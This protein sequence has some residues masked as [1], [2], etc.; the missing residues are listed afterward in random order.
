MYDTLIS[1]V[2][3]YCACWRWAPKCSSLDKIAPLSEG[4][5]SHRYLRHSKDS[6]PWLQPHKRNA[7]LSLKEQRPI[8]PSLYLAFPH[9]TDNCLSQNHPMHKYNCLARQFYNIS[10]GYSLQDKMS[11]HHWVDQIAQLWTNRTAHHILHTVIREL[12]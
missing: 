11:K 12:S 1:Q 3:F 10:V 2:T 4:T 5:L 8:F 9:S 7:Y 6:R